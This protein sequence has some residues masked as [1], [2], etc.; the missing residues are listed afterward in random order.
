MILES[1][2]KQDMALASYDKAL[3]INPTHLSA[4]INKG[5]ILNSLGHHEEALDFFE[6]AIDIDLSDPVTFRGQASSLFNL[7]RYAEALSSYIESTELRSRRC[8][9]H[10][11]GW[12]HHMKNWGYTEML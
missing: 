1:I 12:A 7:G 9:L 6:R 4:L 10:G 2:G 11:M 5:Y 8:S 3:E